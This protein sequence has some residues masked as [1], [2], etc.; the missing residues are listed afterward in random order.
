ME[1]VY[2][3]S[4]MI[5]SVGYE[6]DSAILEIEFKTNNAV[7]NYY[8]VPEYVH[9]E[10]MNADSVGK[11]FHAQIKDQYREARVG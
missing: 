3:D 2:V 10:M 5:I 7:W 8:D 6:S 11:F 1:R 9:D 4:S